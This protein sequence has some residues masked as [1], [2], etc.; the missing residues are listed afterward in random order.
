M[1]DK[2]KRENVFMKLALEREAKR[3]ERIARE[4][5]PMTS[6]YTPQQIAE[7]R[8]LSAALNKRVAMRRSKD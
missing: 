3:Q 1:I 5:E 8:A 6:P 2:P 4:G 7:G